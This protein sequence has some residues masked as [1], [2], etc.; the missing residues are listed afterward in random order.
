METITLAPSSATQQS[1]KITKKPSLGDIRLGSSEKKVYGCDHVK[2]LLENARPEATKQY[3]RLVQAI[4]KDNNLSVRL[5]KISSGTAPYSLRPT[6]LCLQCPNVATSESRDAHD[7][8]HKF[9]AESTSGYIYCRACSDIIHDPHF[10]EIRLLRGRKRSHSTFRSDVDTKILAANSSPVPCRAVGLR[11]LYN[12]GQT[13]FMSVVLQSLIH[14]PFIRAYYLSESHRS[15]ECERDCCTSCALDDIFSEFHSQEKAEG[16]GLVAMLQSSWR[17]GGSLAGYQQQDAHEYLQFILNSLHSANLETDEK[18]EKAEDC[19]CIIHRTFCGVL[20]ST[21]TCSKCKNVTTAKDPFMD[22]SLDVKIPGAAKAKK[23]NKI[24]MTT[25]KDKK[26]KDKNSAA[27]KD[28][29]DKPA[30]ALLECFDRFTSAESLPATDYTCRKCDA[31]QAAT[32]RLSLA[33]MPPVL[34]V[35]LKRFSHSK[36]SGQGI[37]LDTKVRFPMTVDLGP[38]VT[39]A[40]GAK[41]KGEVNGKIKEEEGKEKEKKEEDGGGG[42]GNR[43]IYELS[44]V[45]VHKGKMDSGHYISFSRVYDEWFMFDDSKVVLVEE[46]D[47]LASEAYMLFYVVRDIDV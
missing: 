5:P 38:Y 21:V 39:G 40:G 30:M 35:H 45:I 9:C 23:E 26:D 6:W 29:E 10:D 4:N 13:C 41:K 34:P 17:G 33:R 22:L 31:Q 47:V 20:Q 36:N 37:K 43:P 7:K 46:S 27:D 14:N 18:E 12:M 2:D 28:K 42:K 3:T 8:A 1:P 16:Y 11:G 24:S 15:T 44:S 32:K 19:P 25:G